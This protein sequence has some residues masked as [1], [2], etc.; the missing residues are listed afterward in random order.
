MRKPQSKN[1][2]IAVD[3][4]PGSLS[5]ILKPML[6]DPS[7]K[8]LTRVIALG[9]E[10]LLLEALC[11]TQN[12]AASLGLAEPIDAEALI[13]QLWP[14]WWFFFEGESQRFY[15]L[16]PRSYLSLRDVLFCQSFSVLFWVIEDAAK[17]TAKERGFLQAIAFAGAQQAIVLSSQQNTDKGEALAREFLQEAGFNGNLTPFIQGESNSQST[18][19]A[20]H[21]AFEEL[22]PTKKEPNHPH[23][24]MPIDQVVTTSKTWA[25]SGQIARGQVSIGD[26]IELNGNQ[27]FRA[28]VNEIKPFG[29][30]LTTQQAIAGYPV[31]IL[32]ENAQTKREKMETAATPGFLFLGASFDAEVHCYTTNQGGLRRSWAPGDALFLLFYSEIREA[33]ISDGALRP[34]QTR[35]LSFTLNRKLRLVIGARFFLYV[36]EAI[37]AIGSVKR[38][39]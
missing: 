4:S 27:K 21:K 14:P 16:S 8:P 1:A 11:G 33:T 17:I 22:A 6:F 9:D 32:V 29:K 31:T 26:I 34:G 35:H 36:G 15:S 30:Q 28:K 12:Y 19:E 10:A 7:P 37:I 3:C 38:I 25:I 2:K 20:L 18:H 23:F 39:K 5:L 24:Y 13:E